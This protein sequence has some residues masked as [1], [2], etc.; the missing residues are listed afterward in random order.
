[1]LVFALLEQSDLA[2]R[3][4][5]LAPRRLEKIL[6]IQSYRLISLLFLKGFAL[7]GRT[8]IGHIFHR[9]LGMND[10]LGKM[11]GISKPRLRQRTCG[12]L[13]KESNSGKETSPHQ[14][15]SSIVPENYLRRARK[16][17]LG[18]TMTV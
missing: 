7:L 17:T 12:V 6:D 5:A 4:Y 8:L 14:R 15:I 18:M 11:G 9:L 10:N 1:M 13:Q 2:R 3:F 16:S